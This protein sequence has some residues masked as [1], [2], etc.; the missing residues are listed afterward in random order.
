[1]RRDLSEVQYK[2]D[3]KAEEAYV[4]KEEKQQELGAAFQTRGGLCVVDAEKDSVESRIKLQDG[5]QLRS[6]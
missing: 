4:F 1:M 2:E 5:V 6:E 3:D